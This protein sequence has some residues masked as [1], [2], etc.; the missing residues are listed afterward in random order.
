MLR[1][2]V[3]EQSY[4]V[5]TLDAR[6]CESLNYQAA[7][8]AID[9]QLASIE[10]GQLCSIQL[11]QAAP[12][13]RLVSLYAPRFCGEALQQW[14][15]IVEMGPEEASEFFDGC[16]NVEGL[17]F[18]A[19]CLDD[20]PDLPMEYVTAEVFPW[21]DWRVTRAAVRTKEGEWCTGPPRI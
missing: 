16:R 15:V 20:C 7:G 5:H 8:G 13:S 17:D 1:A 9:A 6:V 4:E 14:S 12:H 10:S 3:K 11:R 2:L 19:L 18:V 21:D